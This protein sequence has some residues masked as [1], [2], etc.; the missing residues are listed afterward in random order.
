M[1]VLA[2]LVSCILFVVKCEEKSIRFRFF[3]FGKMLS[4]EKLDQ[5]DNLTAREIRE[6]LQLNLR[7]RNELKKDYDSLLRA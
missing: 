5:L 7:I 4:L 3:Q 1:F 2:F 6:L